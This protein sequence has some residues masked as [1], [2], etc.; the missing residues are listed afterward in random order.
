[1]SHDRILV[2][3]SRGLVGQAV[4]RY[5]R[6][7][8]AEHVVPVSRDVCDLEDA[9]AVD[10]LFSRHRP[11]HVYH[12][13]ARVGGI[14]ANQAD[15]MGFMI[16]NL[17]LTLNITE[18]CLRHGAGKLALMGSN[19]AYPRD[20]PQPMKEEFFLTG[21]LEPTNEGYALA[22]IIAMRI[23]SFAGR[24]FGLRCIC[25]VFCGLYGPGD[26]FD[27]R[28]SH[29]LSALVRRYVDA[30]DQGMQ[31]VVLWGTGAPLRE[32]MHVDDAARALVFLMDRYD[33]PEHINVGSENEISIREL[34]ELIAQK[35]G[36]C[37]RTRFDSSKP[38]GMPR[39]CLDS[40]RMRGLG[41]TPAITMAQGLEH[42][43]A[44]YRARREQG[45]QFDRL[46]SG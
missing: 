6:A 17:K 10:R 25:P 7:L 12:L 20:C 34:A 14:A 42:V 41:F 15:P 2:T 28:R 46:A 37:G 5:L 30:R 23:G 3:G 38:D 19:C 4:V 40:S 18:A 9:A 11:T 22:K 13:A 45:E 8:G 39:K 1:M 24:Q 29:V 44:D 16:A 33:S 36:Y 43:I 26:S 32:F 35:V 31:E 21:P 27:A